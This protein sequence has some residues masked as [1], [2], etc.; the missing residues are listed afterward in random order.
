MTLRISTKEIAATKVV[1]IVMKVTEQ[2]N[3]PNLK[4]QGAGKQPFPRAAEGLSS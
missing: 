2:T 3:L 4:K 1:E